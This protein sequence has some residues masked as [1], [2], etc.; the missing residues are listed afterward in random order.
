MCPCVRLPRQP[1]TPFCWLL[2]SMQA[3]IPSARPLYT[4]V[5]A[6][7]GETPAPVPA[8]FCSQR[9]SHLQVSPGTPAGPHGGAAGPLLLSIVLSPLQLPCRVTSP[10]SVGAEVPSAPLWPPCPAHLP[11]QHCWGPGGGF[12]HLKAPSLSSAVENTTH[13]EFAY[14]RDLLIR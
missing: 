11:A 9:P 12:P 4:C 10:R 14:L 8:S 6:R 13:C 5:L 1:M 2:S 7:G 3:V